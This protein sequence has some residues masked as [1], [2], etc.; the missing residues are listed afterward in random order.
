VFARTIVVRVG[1]TLT[2]GWQAVCDRYEVFVI[3]RIGVAS[4]SDE[5]AIQVNGKL[6]GLVLGTLSDTIRRL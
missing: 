3:L 2:I 6:E 4:I 1:W 5:D